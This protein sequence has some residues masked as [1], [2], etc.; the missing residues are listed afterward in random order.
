APVGGGHDQAPEEPVLA[1]HLEAA[2]PHEQPGVLHH[3]EM[4]ELI[5]DTLGRQVR[6]AQER[7]R[8][9]E[10]VRPRGLAEQRHRE[11][12]AWQSTTVAREGAP[13]MWITVLVLAAAAADAKSTPVLPPERPWVGKSVSLVADAKDP[14]STPAERSGFTRTPRYDETVAWLRK[15]VADAPQLPLLPLGQSPHGRPARLVAA[16]H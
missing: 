10:V 9:L 16:S 11:I 1:V 4:A 15:L 6:I 3:E 7:E 2:E 8:G 13:P 12:L 5:D 14:W